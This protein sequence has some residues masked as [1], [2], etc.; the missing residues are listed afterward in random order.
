MNH[1]WVCSEF[2]LSCEGL[3]IVQ[4]N[5]KTKHDRG[6]RLFFALWPDDDIRNNIDHRFSSA[7]QY[8]SNGRILHRDNLHITLHFIGNVSHQS[9]LCLQQAALSVD[10]K[11][12]Q[13]TLNHFDY[14]K[15]AKVF[16]MG[17]QELKPALTALHESLGDALSVCDYKIESRV[18]NPHV[19]LMRK[20]LHAGELVKFAPIFWSV[21]DFVLV[22]SISIESGVRYEVRQRYPL[23]VL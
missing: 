5:T 10:A 14:F 13:L 11:S 12:F 4:L 2:Y 21:K 18:Y 8:T 3:F 19:T 22:E 16:Y 6:H 17:L 7:P 9:M 23:N 15:K 1:C 20:L